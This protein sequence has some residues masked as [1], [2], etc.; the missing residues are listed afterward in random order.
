MKTFLLAATVVAGLVCSAGTAD[1]QYRYRRGASY[2]YT[3]PTYSYPTYTYSYPSYSYSYPTYYGS[4]VTSSY[5]PTY[6]GT[7]VTSSYTPSS[8]VIVTDGYT[9]STVVYPSTYYS[10]SSSNVYNPVWDYNYPTYTGSSYYTPSGVYW[11]GRRIWR[12]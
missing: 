9:P 6:D 4:A 5:T 7:V 1:A 8:S 3:Y 2:S 12:W 11:G 10:G